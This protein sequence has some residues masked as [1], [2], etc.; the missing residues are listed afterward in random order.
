MIAQQAQS[1]C[2]QMTYDYQTSAVRLKK[3]IRRNVR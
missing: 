2:D 3:E 1:K